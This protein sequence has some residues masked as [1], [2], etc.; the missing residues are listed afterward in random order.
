MSQPS[1]G[2]LKQAEEHLRAGRL[3]E[4]RAALIQVLNADP[5]SPQAWWLLSFAVDE[6]ERKIECMQRFL[7][8]RPD[9]ARARERLS[10][11]QADAGRGQAP[12]VAVP[13]A[14]PSASVTGQTAVRE[15]R[16]PVRPKRLPW[17]GVLISLLVIVSVGFAFVLFDWYQRS[18]AQARAQ[19]QQE[20]LQA[21]Q[22]LTSLP[23]RT[24]PATWT[25][26]PSWTPKPSITPSET[27][28]LVPSPSFLLVLPGYPAPDFTLTDS[29]GGEKVSLSQFIGMPVLMVFMVSW[30]GACGRE[31]PILQMIY[32]K[33]KD[34]GL[35]VLGVDDGED[36]STV[37][38]FRDKYHLTFPL[39]L[40]T[41]GRVFRMYKAKYYPSQFYIR[42]D[43]ILATIDAR[44]ETV[45]DLE[46]R[47]QMLMQGYLT[48]TPSI[49]PALE[50]TATP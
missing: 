31:A 24:L 48:P 33:Y 49:A 46:V 17:T 47:V 30:C 25:P 29:Q 34:S 37:Q 50:P 19:G 12:A 10:Q 40:D 18:A 7:R 15:A 21:A 9:N 11:L 28:T 1:E 36:L 8:L 39:L 26:S 3:P 6:P 35:V 42:P 20:T 44:V 4:A 23:A 32:T 2:I 14:K 43:G 27:L 16:G 22:V 38:A 45:G 41:T 13:A 5:E